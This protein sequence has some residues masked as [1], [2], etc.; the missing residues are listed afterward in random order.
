MLAVDTS[1]LARAITQDHPEQTARAATLLR[2]QEIWISKTVILE[3]EW[4]FRRSYGFGKSRTLAALRSLAGPDNVRL[5]DSSAVARALEWAEEAGLDFADALHLASC[6]EAERFL[7][8][9]QS[10]ARQAKALA[11]IKVAAV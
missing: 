1:I 7:T 4:V 10:L 5:E 11:S 2:S 6:G 8:F 3:L 9:D